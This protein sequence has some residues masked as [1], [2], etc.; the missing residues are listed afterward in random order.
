MCPIA[1]YRNFNSEDPIPDTPRASSPIVVGQLGA[2]NQTGLRRLIS[3]YE[4]AVAEYHAVESLYNDK[5]LHAAKYLRDTAEN[6]ILYLKE[7]DIDRGKL[8]EIEAMYE[9]AKHVVQSLTGKI[10]KFDEGYRPREP[11]AEGSREEGRAPRGREKRSYEHEFRRPAPWSTTNRGGVADE[12]RRPAS[13]DPYAR[14]ADEG[15][16]RRRSTSPVEHEDRGTSRRDRESEG[17]I[18]IKGKGQQGKGHSGIPFGY[19]EDRTVDRYQP[20]AY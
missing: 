13:P 5:T 18:R 16:R 3:T 15:D 10:R 1:E 8:S 7:T 11:Q 6:T 19:R 4:T 12:V 2:R 9:S 20:D 14:R 17:G